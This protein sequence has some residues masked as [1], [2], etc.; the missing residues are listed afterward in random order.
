MKNKIYIKAYNKKNKILSSVS[1]KN[2]Q[3]LMDI[4]EDGEMFL[5]N[6]KTITFYAFINKIDS[7][8][9]TNKDKKIKKINLIKKSKESI[10]P[11]SQFCPEDLTITIDFSEED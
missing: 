8:Y 4:N 6:K 10:L 11:I 5:K 2:S 1:L 7:V 3:W 9:F